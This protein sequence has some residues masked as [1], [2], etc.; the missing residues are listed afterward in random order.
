MSFECIVGSPESKGFK[1]LKN[2]AT[3]FKQHSKHCRLCP[4]SGKNNYMINNW[5]AFV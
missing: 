5:N 2:E 4:E 3:F 1:D